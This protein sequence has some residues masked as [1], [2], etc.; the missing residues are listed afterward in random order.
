MC[1]SW[2]LANTKAL[3]LTITRRLSAYDIVLG[4]LFYCMP[5]DNFQRH[6][7]VVI[8]YV[9]FV[10]LFSLVMVVLLGRWLVV[11]LALAF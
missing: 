1:C 3:N 2:V 6:C 7:M 10:V 5:L 8:C 9:V 4:F 11:F